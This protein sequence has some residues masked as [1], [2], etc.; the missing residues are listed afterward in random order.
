MSDKPK[1]YL[2]G[3]GMITPIGA[4]TEMTAVAVRA[5]V[6][7]YCTTSFYVSEDDHVRMA[8][9]PAEALEHCLNKD[10]LANDYAARQMRMLRLATMALV[11]L[12]PLLPANAK[13]P[14]F[15]AGPEQLIDS[16]RPIHSGFLTDVI[17]QTGV[18]LNLPVSRI[19]STGRA[20][21]LAA[22]DLAF[23]FFASSDES[24]V[25]VGGVDTFYDGRLLQLL[26]KERR[27]LVGG[28]MDGFVPGEGAAFI[29]LSR[30]EA[31]LSQ[32]GKRAVCLYEPGVGAEAG[33]RASKEP[34]RGDGLAATVAHA[35]DNAAVG[36]IKIWYSSMNGEHFWAKENGVAMVRNSDRLEEGIKIEHPAD[37]FGDLGAAFG[38]VAIGVIAANIE[39]NKIMPPCLVCCSSDLAPRSAVVVHA[40]G[41]A[42]DSSEIGYQ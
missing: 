25:I 2:A 17:T 11:Q 20:G 13:P 36:K 24:F 3:T 23:R 35:L 10:A 34:Y 22:I 15:L 8:L 5:G 26:L 6:S 7:G 21:G 4:N 39:K 32:M 37:C 28:N 9:V 30:H 41:A 19:I 40:S 42:N 33:H 31:A 29:L 14:L 1:L 18:A 16:D 27:L 38:P 12:G